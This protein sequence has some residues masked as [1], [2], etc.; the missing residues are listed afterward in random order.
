M[1]VTEHFEVSEFD[2][3][4]RHGF[5]AVPYPNEWISSKLH[6]LCETLEIIRSIWNKPLTILSGY[7]TREYNRKIG[8]A[9]YSRHVEGIACDFKIKGVPIDNVHIFVMDYIRSAKLKR[10]KGLGRY[11]T[12]VH[13][14]LRPQ[15]W[16][17]RWSGSRITT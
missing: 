9:T 15:T 4:A 2:Q 3:P 10:I 6:S 14:D 1:F 13:I 5:S 17:S 12:F 11:P 8:G 16:L 7:R